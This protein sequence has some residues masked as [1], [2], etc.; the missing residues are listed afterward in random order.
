[1]STISVVV[2]MSG[3]ADSAAAAWML[4]EKGYRV[5][6]VTLRLYCSARSIGS[7]RP[8]CSDASLGRARR[9]CAKLGLHHHVVDVEDEFRATVVKNFIEEYRAGRTPNPCIV[10]NEKIKFPALLRIADRLGCERIATGH[11]ARFVRGNEGAVFL[12]A[13]SDGAKDQ[14]YFLYRVPVNALGRTLFPLGEMPKESVKGIVSRLGIGSRDQRS[15]QDICFIPAGNLRGFLIE[16]LGRSPGEVVDGDGRVLGRHDGT[17]LYTKGQRKGFGIAGGAPL[18]VARIDRERNRVVLGPREEGF[19][20]G[21][22]CRSLR[23][24]SRTLQG[25]LGAR[26]RYRRPLAEVLGVERSGGCCTV[27]FREPQ[28]AVTPGQSLV[29]YRDGVVLGGGI[30][31]REMVR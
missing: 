16:H 4:D 7:R 18:Y 5:V 25:A 23:L 14:S 24:R 19:S 27:V 12:A 8:C 15:S 29:L 2:G 20:D 1:M 21:A 3:G 17:H 31:E 28:W 22:L 11:Y 6:G 30:I 26:V 9:L 10:C 13:A